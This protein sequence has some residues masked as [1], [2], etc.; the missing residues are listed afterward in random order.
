VKTHRPGAL[1]L[2]A[3][4]ALCLA[5]S[6]CGTASTGTGGLLGSQAATGSPS[7]AVSKDALLASIK[8]LG[9]TSYKY[10]GTQAGVTLTGVADPPKKAANVSARGTVS[11]IAIK[12]DVI[13]IGND[14]WVKADLGSALN[15]QLG[16]KTTRWMHVDTTKLGAA[17]NLPF[18]LAGG[19]V[20]DISGLLNGV[21][22]VHRTDARHYTGTI[23]LTSASGVSALSQDDLDKLGAK[24]KAMPFTATLD[25]RGRLVDVAVDTSSV[26]KSVSFKLAISDYGAPVAIAKPASSVEAPAGVYQLF[27]K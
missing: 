20:L 4:A 12:E 8:E 26:D 9:T 18:H 5:V 24:A 16:V 21:T 6:A 23:N 14:L 17:A 22:D 2:S 15:R 19:D 13:G 10:T 25:E 1:G 11:G 3:L 7:P 27:K